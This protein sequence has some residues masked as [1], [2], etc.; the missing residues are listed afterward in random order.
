M[1][2][3]VGAGMVFLGSAVFSLGGAKTMTGV[4]ASGSNEGKNKVD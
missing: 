4:S 3:V 2:L 1:E